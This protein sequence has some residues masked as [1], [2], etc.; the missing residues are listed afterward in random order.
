MES[1]I[2]DNFIDMFNQL[3]VD[4]ETVHLDSIFTLDEISEGGKSKEEIRALW[5]EVVGEGKKKA[6]KAEFVRFLTRLEELMD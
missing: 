6:N 3:A 5:W 2:D 1:Q 4:Y